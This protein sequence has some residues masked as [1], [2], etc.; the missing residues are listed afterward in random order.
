VVVAIPAVMSVTALLQEAP[1]R[2]G[3]PAPRTVIAPDLIRVDDPAATELA[4][5]L[6][7]DA[8][9]PVLVS[10]DEAK[11]AVVQAVS[12]RFAAAE[13]ARQPAT[14][15]VAVPSMQEQVQAILS[16]IPVLEENGARRLASLPDNQ[17]SEV[18]AQAIDIAQLYARDEVPEGQ[19][20]ADVNRLLRNE[21]AVRTFPPGV[22][23]EVI[24]PIIRDAARPTVRLD[25]AKTEALRSQAADDVA[26]V[27]RT[28]ARGSVIVS[29]GEVVDPQQYAALQLRGLEGRE[30]WLEAL[31]ALA[32][33]LALTAVVALY[34]QAYRRSV[35]QA[36]RKLLLL[37]V[38][39]LMYVAALE[40]ASLLVPA[41]RTAM[42]YAVPVGAVAMLATILFDPPVG[43]LLA[44]PA[45]VLVA[46]TVP[47]EAGVVAFA[48]VAS[49]LSV[50]LVSRLS[51]RGDLRRAAWQ[52]TLG[53]AGIAAVM[54][55]VFS[56]ADSVLP[57]AAAGLANGVISAVVLN[58]SLPFLES[59]FGILTATSLLDLADRNH[60]LLRELERKALGS[61]NHSIMVSTMCE[62][63][64]RSIHADSL[65]AS[66]AA[67]Y[68]D[69]GKVRRPYFFVENQFG[70]ENPHDEL[71]P[72]QSALI[73]QDHV[74]DGVEMA[75][76]VRLPP[77]I[78]GGIASHHGTT[79]VSFF[80]S[81]AVAEAD[82]DPAHP[83]VDEA[84]FRYKGRKPS[85][86][87]M[88][89]LM[90]ADCC[91]GA[92]RAAA[93]HNRNLSRDD[94]DGIVRGLVADRVEDGQLDECA[95]TFRELADVQE[96][97]IETL[98]GVYHPRI[99]YP[100]KPRKNVP[101]N[102]DVVAAGARRQPGKPAEAQY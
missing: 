43:V 46:F 68:H 23:D 27:Q 33:V 6:A 28:F 42:Y 88:G 8:V 2:E 90:L 3:E 5:R 35:W 24:A 36:A 87:E 71:P 32:L 94:L 74:S 73:I 45:T 58:G 97:F 66:T 83:Q 55:A 78:V 54:A 1:L 22:A 91:E 4:R 85:S 69:I 75:R 18:A 12:D 7:A 38:I 17:L 9:E 14:D 62:R 63:A 82:A 53:Y 99:A 25:D 57:A 34:L 102:S 80:Y 86:K 10:D 39:A 52:S 48:A 64:A 81:R 77:E 29:A 44:L 15:G 79:L 101:A 56:G 60:P 49:L 92:S 50:P 93:Q 19:V 47:G 51:A 72:E 96:S 13:A 11:A 100:G 76:Q 20:E 41:G 59:V 40:T 70:I 37:A 16:R 89:I 84:H 67:L 31:R 26:P 61:Y 95:L 21:F 30:P 65:L 98:V